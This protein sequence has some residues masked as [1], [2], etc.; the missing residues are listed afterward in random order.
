MVALLN[1]LYY[2][3]HVLRRLEMDGPRVGAMAQKYTQAR[4]SLCFHSTFLLDFCFCAWHLVDI[5]RLLQFHVRSFKTKPRKHDPCSLFI[6]EQNFFQTFLYLY[7]IRLLFI[8]CWLGLSYLPILNEPL[9]KE[10]VVTKHNLDQGFSKGWSLDQKHQHPLGT[11]QR[12]TNSW[13]PSLAIVNVEP[14]SLF[15][16]ILLGK[17]G[18]FSSLRTIGLD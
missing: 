4:F 15:Q 13:T 17:S 9:V 3:F 6:R 5:S 14:G 16:T 8:A 18:T 12:D 10:N 2:L 11:Y 1:D 7:S